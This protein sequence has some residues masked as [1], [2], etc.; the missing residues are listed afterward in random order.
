MTEGAPRK[1]KRVPRRFSQK[2]DAGYTSLLGGPSDPVN[3]Y[4]VPKYHPQPHTYGIVDEASAVLSMARNSSLNEKVRRVIYSLQED[5][6]LLMAELA[7]TPEA[8]GGSG[9]QITPAHVRRLEELI[10][11]L[12]GEVELPT[13]FVTSSH[14]FP[15]ATI[16]LARA[17]VRRAEREAARLRHEN[18]ITNDEV[19]KYLN[20]CADLLWTLARYEEAVGGSQGGGPK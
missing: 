5:L 8:A 10:A 15:A 3:R 4:R 7:T 20:R 16:D 17:V 6:V 13:R 11:E 2:G 12:Q 9:Y 19:L 1:S 18:T 14:S